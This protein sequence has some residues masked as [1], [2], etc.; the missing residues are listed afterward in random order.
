M[1]RQPWLGRS[2]SRGCTSV[3][4]PRAAGEHGAQSEAT[5]M[6]PTHKHTPPH[7]HT[8]QYRFEQK[9]STMLSSLPGVEY[10][11]LQRLEPPEPRLW[12]PSPN[13]LTE[14][15][16]RVIDSPPRSGSY[17]HPV[18]PCITLHPMKR[19]RPHFCVGRTGSHLLRT[20]MDGTGARAAANFLI[21]H[22]PSHLQTLAFCSGP[23]S[24]LCLRSPADGQGVGCHRQGRKGRGRDSRRQGPPA[25][26]TGHAQAR[27]G[28]GHGGS[29]SSP[30][31]S[32]REKGR[33]GVRLILRP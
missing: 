26:R 5:R 3:S 25:S 33:S 20:V 24:P 27:L 12:I 11:A 30:P 19:T 7:K 18:S 21:S 1:R 13:H 4:R 9:V 31:S 28:V 22:P 8:H 10:D 6:T 14:Q 23:D 2:P 15:V 17:T 32:Q 16:I 29:S